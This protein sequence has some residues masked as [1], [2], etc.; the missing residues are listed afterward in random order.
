MNSERAQGWAATPARAGGHLLPH[1]PICPAVCLS[2]LAN[3]TSWTIP[4]AHIC[5]NFEVHPNNREVLMISWEQDGMSSDSQLLTQ[6]PVPSPYPPA[7]VPKSP[8]LKD[9]IV[10]GAGLKTFLARLL[11]GQGKLWNGGVFFLP[12]HLEVKRKKYFSLWKSA[13]NSQ[14]FRSDPGPFIS[15]NLFNFCK[16]IP[17]PTGIWLRKISSRSPTKNSA[18]ASEKPAH[19]WDAIIFWSDL[20]YGLE[21]MVGDRGLCSPRRWFDAI[22]KSSW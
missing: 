22:A 5:G 12:S 21:V 17:L 1:W 14:D 9:F 7:E 4:H 16:R 19:L 13:E 6:G 18:S 15:P 3:P 20:E 2:M 8:G 10:L 11:S